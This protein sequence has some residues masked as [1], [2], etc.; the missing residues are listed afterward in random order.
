MRLSRT[1]LAS[2]AA[3]V[4]APPASPRPRPGHA[5]KEEKKPRVATVAYAPADTA[6]IHPGVQ[7]YTDGAQCTAN[8]V[9]DDAAGNTYV[10]YAAHCAGTGAAT[11]TNGC[12][13][14]SLPLGTKVDFVQGGSP[15]GGTT[16]G[17][18]TLVYS[19]WLSMQQAGTTDANACDY[20]DFALVKVDAADVAKVNPSLPFWGGPTGLNTT[21]APTGSGSTPT[22][23]PAFVPASSR[24]HPRPAP[25]SA[26]AVAAGRTTSTP[27][28][29]ASRATR[30]APSSMARAGPSGPCPPSSSHRWRGP[31]GSVT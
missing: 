12:D 24:S 31:T 9:F 5:A 17:G 22:A 20:N 18:G 23:T 6:Q 16:V 21:G 10:G 30:E 7:M 3:A 19:S 1:L 13:A 14:G 27:R 15:V 4:L 8:F 29:P 2:A 28:L 25:A 26:P 11:D